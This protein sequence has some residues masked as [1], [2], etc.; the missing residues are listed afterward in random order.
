M[1]R[2]HH[3]KIRINRPI[4]WPHKGRGFSFTNEKYCPVKVP[5]QERPSDCQDSL[6]FCEFCQKFLDHHKITID[7]SSKYHSIPQ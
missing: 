4:L 6:T 2:A 3:P 5:Y 1:K 7:S